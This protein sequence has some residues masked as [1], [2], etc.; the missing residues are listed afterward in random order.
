MK[1]LGYSVLRLASGFYPAIRR[2]CTPAGILALTVLVVS[3]VVGI[4]TELTLAYQLF[5]FVFALTVVSAAGAWRFRGPFTVQ[6]TLPLFATVGEPI[7]YRINVRNDSGRTQSGLSVMEELA[8]PRPGYD[9]FAALAPARRWRAFGMQRRT[10]GIARQPLST[11]PP[12]RTISANMEFVPT[13]RGAIDFARI[14]VARLDPLGLFRAIDRYACSGSLLV[15]PK[16]YALPELRLPGTRAY[17]HGGVTLATSVGDSEEFMGL[18]DYRPGDP[19]QHVHW[20]SFART[21][22]PIV[23]EY[24]SEFFERHA[25][26]LD[27][28]TD[29]NTPQLEDA[30]SLAASFVC[31][32]ETQ[33]NLLD[34]LFVGAD[35]YCHTVG[36]G[37]MQVE[38]LLEVLAHVRPCDDKPFN[39]LQPAVLGRRSALSGCILILIAWDDARQQ[40]VNALRASGLPLVVYVVVESAADLTERQPW[41]RVLESGRI[42][43]G[44]ARCGPDPV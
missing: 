6:R 28:F 25:L 44:L 27:T 30:V 37:Q 38:N 16:R 19:L 14:S 34:L 22:T 33:E 20:K 17:Q 5:A 9:E 10:P 39:A 21:G 3:A 26:V 43:E 32:I 40:L 1:R 23:K 35:V 42:E 7:S 13:R 2:R 8:D 15:L 31:T 4:D 12:E 41:L 18:R 29:D 24:Q 11:L 36:R